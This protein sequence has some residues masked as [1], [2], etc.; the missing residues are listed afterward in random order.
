MGG[1]VIPNRGGCNR[2]LGQLNVSRAIG[3]KLYKP[4]LI[5][6]PEIIEYKLNKNDTHLIFATDGLWNEMKCQ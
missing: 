4:F 3:D 2:V 6:D 1:W 5:P